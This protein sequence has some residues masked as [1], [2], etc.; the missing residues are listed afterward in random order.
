MNPGLPKGV[1]SRNTVPDDVIC[2][3]VDV[4]RVTVDVIRVSFDVILY[5]ASEIKRNSLLANNLTA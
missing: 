3:T 1:N 5:D 2:I 4:I